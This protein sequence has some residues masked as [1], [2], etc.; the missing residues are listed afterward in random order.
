MIKRFLFLPLSLQVMVLAFAFCACAFVA[1]LAAAWRALLVFP[2]WY[3]AY[4]AFAYVLLPLALGWL[5]MRRHALFVHFCIVECIGLLSGFVIHTDGLL[6]GLPVGARIVHQLLAVV[7][8]AMALMLVNK[9]ILFPFIFA[10]YRG[11]RRA[12]RVEVNQIVAVSSPR[13]GT[14]T[15]MMIEDCSTT[16]L[17][18][19]GHDA[20]LGAAL[21]LGRG[22]QLMVRHAKGRTDYQVPVEILWKT[23]SGSITKIGVIATD[24]VSMVDFFE[25]LGFKQHYS[26]PRRMATALWAKGSVRRGLSYAFAVALIAVLVAPGLERVKR[27]Q[28]LEPRAWAEAFGLV[29]PRDPKAKIAH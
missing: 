20:T 26:W 6:A 25:G 17:A 22:E 29:E 1:V 28:M 11:F 19:Y 13:L 24:A 23:G 14:T 8:G 16:G 15:D 9:D 18:L 27:R 5:I 3:N 12:P 7:V 21:E 10:S 2:S 4:L